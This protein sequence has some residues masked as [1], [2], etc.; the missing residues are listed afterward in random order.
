MHKIKRASHPHVNMQA[1]DT[2]D[3]VAGIEF[4][5]QNKLKTSFVANGR[6]VDVNFVH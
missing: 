4:A 1:A 5:I 2:A 6:H 3:M